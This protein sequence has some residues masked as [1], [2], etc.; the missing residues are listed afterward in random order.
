MSQNEFVE[1]WQ[2]ASHSGDICKLFEVVFFP[3]GVLPGVFRENK[4]NEIKQG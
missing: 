4:G 1:I 3:F 2:I